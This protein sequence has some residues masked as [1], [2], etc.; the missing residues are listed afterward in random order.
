MPGGIPQGN[1]QGTPLLPKN[2]P[3]LG[4][5]GNPTLPGLGKPGIGGFPGIGKKK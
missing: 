5:L 2:F 1:S 3:G 4:G